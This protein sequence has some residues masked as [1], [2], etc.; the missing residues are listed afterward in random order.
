MRGLAQAAIQ[1]GAVV[2]L[3]GWVFAENPGDRQFQQGL[4]YERLGRLTES[5]SELQIASALQPQNAQ[6]ALA[7]G[8]VAVRLGKLEVAQRA[9]EQSISIDA[10]SIASYYQL[11][12]LYESK[13]MTDR[14]VDAWHRFVGLTNDATLKQMAEKHLQHLESHE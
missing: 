2:A 1:F 13:S 6:I 3:A 9:L 8:L 4:A 11:G 5:Y 7:L 10:A 14:A 12:F